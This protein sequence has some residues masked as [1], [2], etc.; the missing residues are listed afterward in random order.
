MDKQHQ[1]GEVFHP[2]G[3]GHKIPTSSDTQNVN[4]TSSAQDSEVNANQSVAST[5]QPAT[6]A[7]PSTTANKLPQ[8]PF[9]QTP[10][11][12][13]TSQVPAMGK[14]HKMRTLLMA[15]VV[16]ILVGGA[17]AFAYLGY[18]LPNQPENVVKAMLAN[19]LSAKY[20]KST[21]TTT[22]GEGGSEFKIEANSA[23]DFSDLKNPKATVKISA[24]VG[25]T[26]VLLDLVLA[27]NELAFKLDG[28]DGLSGLIQSQFQVPSDEFE[29]I[30]EALE[31]IFGNWFVV[32]QSM[33]SQAVDFNQ[34]EQSDLDQLLNAGRDVEF[35]NI[36]EILEDEQVRE[37]S[38]YHYRLRI[39]D[40]GVKTLLDNIKGKTLAGQE[41]S[42]EMIEQAKTAIDEDP[43]GEADI[44]DVW[45][46]KDSK[47]LAKIY[48]EAPEDSGMTGTFT[49]E[50]YDYDVPVEVSTP[51]NTKSL[52]ELTSLLDGVIQQIFGGSINS[53]SVFETEELPNFENSLN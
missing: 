53:G 35:F 13:P 28:V 19:T 31:G 33:V 16:V 14:K 43:T 8:P 44:F 51:E 21:S 52:L 17:S 36:V 37:Q 12:A 41:I 39:N 34:L 20:S 7:T 15:L 38:A 29:P 26:T 45:I 27:D 18:Y 1:P 3:S 46:Y 24:D 40:E 23:T 48:S 49:A 4:Q 10:Q 50:V 22:Y 42:E 25:L 6:T 30:N 9:G 11:P 2:D 47:R 32:N 5:E